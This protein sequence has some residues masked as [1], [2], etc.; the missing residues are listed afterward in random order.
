[1]AVDVTESPE[2]RL[3][4]I[5]RLRDPNDREA[6][7]QFECIYRPLVYRMA[8]LRGLQDADAHDLVQRVLLSVSQSIEDWNP[9]PGTKFRHWLSKVAKN[10]ALNLLTRQ[11][12]DR[13]QGGS[14][15]DALPQLEDGS[16]L[17]EVE[18]AYELEYQRQLYRCAADLVRS[19]AD[20]KTWLAFSLTMVDGLSIDATSKRLGISSGSVYAARSRIIRRL[21]NEVAKLQVEGE[22]TPHRDGGKS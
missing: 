4:L 2:T 16:D 6:W 7:E 17:S 11:P 3:S 22:T 14:G 13:G 18:Q 5:F 10:A 8:R 9:Q 1:M 12:R 19:R 15:F 21:R 20:E